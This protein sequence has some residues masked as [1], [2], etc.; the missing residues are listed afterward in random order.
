DQ[1]GID[2]RYQKS[3]IRIECYPNPT[4]GKSDI[5]YQISEVRNV[6]LAVYGIYGR[7]IVVLVDETQDAGVHNINFDTSALPDGL[8][9]IRLL[10]GN[11]SAVGKVLVVH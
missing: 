4:Q 2:I 3:E 8:Y 5:R 6:T 10:A 9:I 7:E 11:E 1:T